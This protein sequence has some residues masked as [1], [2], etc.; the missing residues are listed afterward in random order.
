MNNGPK[1]TLN[2]A[3]I[4]RLQSF[5][6]S[7]IYQQIE[8]Y[9]AVPTRLEACHTMQEVI[10]KM[11]VGQLLTLSHLQDRWKGFKIHSQDNTG[12][13]YITI[14]G[15]YGGMDLAGYIHT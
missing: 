14:S 6:L 11:S 13:V 2:L 15:L 7:E 1:S 5:L 9:E 10:S 12:T 4:E 8:K 3:G